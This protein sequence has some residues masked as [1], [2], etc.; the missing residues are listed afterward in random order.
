MCIRDRQ[1]YRDGSTERD[2]Q[3]PLQ[4]THGQLRRARVAASQ[5]DELAEAVHARVEAAV[6]RARA[7]TEP[8]FDAA[9]REVYTETTHG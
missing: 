9:L 6:Q 3:D 7:G 1:K 4:V 2:A 5:L 8:R